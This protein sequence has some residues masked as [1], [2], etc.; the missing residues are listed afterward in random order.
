MTGMTREEAIRSLVVLDQPLPLLQ[1]AL[2]E[3]PWDWEEPAIVML[4]GR[5]VA[6]ILRRY[7]N[8]DLTAEQVE[9]WANLV[10]T[11]DDIEFDAE[12]T[13]AIFCLANPLINGPLTSVAPMLLERL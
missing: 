7:M 1:R 9:T 12:A 3:F 13:D 2:R 5:R 8:G 4:D 10:E 11:R 6:S